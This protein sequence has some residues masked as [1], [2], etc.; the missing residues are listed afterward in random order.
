MAGQKSR[1]PA[2]RVAQ[3]LFDAMP[4][5]RLVT[6]PDAGHMAPMTHPETV[7]R[8]IA[9]ALAAEIPDC[10]APAHRAAA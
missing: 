9:E 3:I 10:A 7:N 5:A 2:R 1:G 6:I 8:L 4:Q